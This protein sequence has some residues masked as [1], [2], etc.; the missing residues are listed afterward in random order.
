MES[1]PQGTGCHSAEGRDSG[2]PS[3]KSRS[4]PLSPGHRGVVPRQQGDMGGGGP[5]GVLGSLWLMGFT[6]MV[7]VRT[8]IENPPGSAIAPQVLRA[9]SGGWGG[10]GGG[11]GEALG[12]AWHGGPGLG[13]G[14]GHWEGWGRGAWGRPGGAGQPSPPPLATL[15]P[16]PPGAQ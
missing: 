9:G 5:E 11:L 2:I 10:R 16:H 1:G 8:G 3:A 4:H 7:L 15:A 6:W 14:R 13:W 12:D